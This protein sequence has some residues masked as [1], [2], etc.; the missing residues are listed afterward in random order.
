MNH[1]LTSTF[2][3]ITGTEISSEGNRYT[4][5]NDLGL[6]GVLTEDEISS[7][8]QKGPWQGQNC[9]ALFEKSKRQIKT[10]LSYCSD[11]FIN[12]VA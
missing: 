8:T 11:C 12:K 2:K 4:N 10:R 1:T 3:N 9:N 5:S 6:W 7:W